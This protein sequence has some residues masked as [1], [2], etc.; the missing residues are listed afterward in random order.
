M[1][2]LF[3]A[4]AF[5][6]AEEPPVL[7]DVHFPDLSPNAS[8]IAFGFQGDIWVAGVEDGLARRLTVSEAYEERPRF[9]PD[10]TQIAFVSD[11]Y[12]NADVFVMPAT[13]GVIR[14]VTYHSA[15]DVLADWSPDGTKLLLSVAGRDHPHTAPYEIELEGGYI[16]PLLLDTCSI[17][18]TGYSPDARFITGIRRGAAWWR[19]A[20]KGSANSQVMVY[21]TQADT[22][23][24]VT[25]FE[26][27]DNWP[28]FVRDGSRICFVSE[29]NGRPN[30][31][32][33]NPDGSDVKPLTDFE[34]DAV[35]FLTASADGKWLVFEWN[36]DLWMLR[37]DG[38][39]PRKITLRAP[40][41]YRRTFETE[42][43]LK[44]GIEEMEVNRDA[45]LAA[46]RLKDDI[47]LVR[48]EFKNDS[49]RV[50]DWPGPDGDYFWSPDGKQLAY[51]SQMNGNS[52]IWVLNP[53]TMEKRCLVDDP[54]FY[55]DM[56]GYTRDGGKI[57][58]RHDV[59]GDGIFAA[60][61]ETGEVSQFLPDPDIE[62]L[63]LSPDGRWL[64]AQIDDG[65]R[66]RTCT[67][68]R[69]TAGSGST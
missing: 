27:M 4:C 31:F 47:F 14:R 43:T 67:S 66:A 5:T 26:G 32:S 30:V 34:R 24:V 48:P 51:I 21:D 45:S 12:G 23:A 69:W 8:Q 60:N 29:R 36:F 42:E 35:T 40:M 56:L 61:P 46:I 11:R 10:G 19:K 6:S 54:Q 39:T 13:G 38:G 68:S 18:I 53:E 37:S 7:R 55:L 15:S 64:L 50:T 44:A 3:L 20:Y 63:A 22:M 28:V 65:G 59:G 1:F 33:M 62:D 25:N 49:I 58:F 17:S 9:S 57:L 52:D 2:P 41:D 16:R